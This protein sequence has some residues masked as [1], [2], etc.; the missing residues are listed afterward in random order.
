MNQILKK[1]E[2]VTIR[3]TS[4]QKRRMLYRAEHE[5]KNLSAYIFDCV[6]RP[7]KIEILQG[8]LRELTKIR[9]QLKQTNS[10]AEGAAI[11]SE[12]NK[13]YHDFLKAI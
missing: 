5:H 4:E 11:V 9:E 13:L 2:T 8:I 10:A 7:E 12:I 1:T 3:L 6:T